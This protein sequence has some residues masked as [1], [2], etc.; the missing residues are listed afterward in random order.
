MTGPTLVV[1]AAGMGSRYGGLKQ[2]EG[3]GPGGEPTIA[4]SIYDAARSGFESVIFVIRPEMEQPFRAAIGDETAR[5]LRTRYAYQ[6]LTSFLP[7]GFE[8][9]AAARQKPWGTAHAVLCCRDLIDGPFAV[10]N[11]DDFYGPASYR[12]LAD[13]L[14]AAAD[15][16]A[17]V[18]DYSMVGF[19]LDK[20]L[21][22]YGE[23]SRGVCRVNAD[24][25][26]ADVTERTRIKRF[27]RAV[28]YAQ[29][30]EW[31][32]LAADSIVSMNMW[33]FTPSFL[34]HVQAGFDMFVAANADKP[35]AEY[36]LPSVVADL[37]AAGKARAAVLPTTETWFGLTY[38]EDRPPARAAIAELI[39]NGV[40]PE[41]LWR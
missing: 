25:T 10:I 4:Y 41:K 19:V 33:G 27:D 16:A 26:L 3:L 37:I 38:P 11:A 5:H 34:G 39:K 32:A 35:K 6:E 30:D 15:S 40:Y 7:K 36:Y 31:V 23:V 29:G 21:S 18:G 1:M 17:G 14:K 28:K 20:T 12:A 8:A 2:L 22:A 24:G 13:H 9:A